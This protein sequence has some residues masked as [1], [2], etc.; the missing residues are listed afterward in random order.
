MF[1]NLHAWH[2]N[3]ESRIEMHSGDKKSVLFN[4]V[5]AARVKNCNWHTC[6]RD[7]LLLQL[8]TTATFACRYMRCHVFLHLKAD[9][10]I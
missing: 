1:I 9:H 4:F 2:P 10:L 6:L 3:I 8:D 7:I 5:L